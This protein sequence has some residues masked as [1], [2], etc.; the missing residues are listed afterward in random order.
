M[1]LRRGMLKTD[2]RQGV[3]SSYGTKI[4]RGTGGDLGPGRCGD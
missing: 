1:G 2:Q 4:W 3:F